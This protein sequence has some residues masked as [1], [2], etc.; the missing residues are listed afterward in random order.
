MSPCPAGETG[1]AGD[2]LAGIAAAFAAHLDPVSAAWCAAH[3]HGRAAER[4]SAATGADRGM[5]AHE[6]ADELPAALAALA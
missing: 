2:T 3:A 1:G 4:W 5:L 6:I